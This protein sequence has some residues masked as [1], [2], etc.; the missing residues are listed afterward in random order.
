MA[1]LRHNAIHFC[2]EHRERIVALCSAA[3][4]MQRERLAGKPSLVKRYRDAWGDDLDPAKFPAPE[5]F[6]R[7]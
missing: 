1:G 5:S 2:P 4:M 7:D 6:D 3:N